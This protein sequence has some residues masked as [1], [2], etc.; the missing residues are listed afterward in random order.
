MLNRFPTM[1]QDRSAEFSSMGHHGPIP[2]EFPARSRLERSRLG[3]P[4]RIIGLPA[5]LAMLAVYAVCR[6]LTPRGDLEISVRL[7]VAKLVTA[8][9]SW[10]RPNRACS[11]LQKVPPDRVPII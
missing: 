10:N 8:L 9:G 6:R 3:Q 7:G 11:P 4:A 5:M 1:E 2:L